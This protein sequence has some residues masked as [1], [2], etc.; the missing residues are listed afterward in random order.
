MLAMFLPVFILAFFILLAGVFVAF[1]RSRLDLGSPVSRGPNYG[2]ARLSAKPLLTPSELDCY[3]KLTFALQPD[4][5]VLAQV[6]M[7]QLFRTSG[8]TRWQNEKLFYNTV[9]N[10]AIDFVICRAD[11]SVLV[12]VE[13]DDP[14]H[15]RKKH[16]DAERDRILR[17]AGYEVLRLPSIPAEDVLQ[18]Y[19][20]TLRQRE[21]AR[22]L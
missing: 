8:G 15:N 21:A 4:F 19:A 6:S 12:V 13:L 1:V 7:G 10:K 17:L 18:C 16:K 2:N 5:V 3:R 14:S 9:A 20:H 22:A 11:L